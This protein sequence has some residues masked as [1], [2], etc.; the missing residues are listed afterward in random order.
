MV[1]STPGIR[2]EISCYKA[3]CNW[4]C[5]V[6]HIYH[7]CQCKLHTQY[8]KVVTVWSM[9][10]GSSAS[11]WKRGDITMLLVGTACSFYNAVD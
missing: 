2:D 5:M 10:V 4:H 11:Q 9:C 3:V 7:S 8:D 1:I 6:M